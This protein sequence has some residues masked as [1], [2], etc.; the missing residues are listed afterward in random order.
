MLR[1]V[2][3]FFGVAGCKGEI[4]L[5]YPT[6]YTSPCALRPAYRVTCRRRLLVTYYSR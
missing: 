3:F 2:V 5:N 4:L 1:C 6:V